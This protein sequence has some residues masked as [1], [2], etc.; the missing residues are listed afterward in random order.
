MECDEKK[1][2]QTFQKSFLKS[3]KSWRQS[4]KNGW[5]ENSRVNHI[6]KGWQENP[7][8]IHIK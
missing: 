8:V 4:Y 2:K 6:T 3:Y 5:Q 7:E 1:S